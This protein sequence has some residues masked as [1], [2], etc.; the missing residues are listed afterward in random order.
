MPLA[1]EF[2]QR[3]NTGAVRSLEPA[4]TGE[5]SHHR[6]IAISV[7]CIDAL[8]VPVGLELVDAVFCVR[9]NYEGNR[10]ALSSQF[11]EAAGGRGAGRFKILFAQDPQLRGLERAKR[12]HGVIA[13]RCTEYI[14]LT[15]LT[16]IGLAEGQDKVGVIAVEILVPRFATVLRS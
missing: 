11:L 1:R 13:E 8:A 2:G 16:E 15:L 12:W 14:G 3:H 9:E 7:A 5:V 10:S 4:V 6:E